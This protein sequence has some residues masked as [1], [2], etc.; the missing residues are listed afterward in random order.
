M[1]FTLWVGIRK[2]CLPL[3]LFQRNEK[4]W[5]LSCSKRRSLLTATTRTFSLSE[6]QYVSIPCTVFSTRTHSSKA[7]CKYFLTK[8]YFSVPIIHFSVNFT[9]ITLFSHQRFDDRPLF[10]PGALCLIYCHIF[11]YKP[12]PNNSK[13]TFTRAPSRINECSPSCSTILTCLFNR[14]VLITVLQYKLFLL[15]FLVFAPS[16]DKSS[17]SSCWHVRIM[18][19]Y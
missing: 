6:K 5:A 17:S 10:K 8:T 13:F 15:M 16:F 18:N 1:N 19:L 7:I 2:H 11:C 9:W 12:I 14:L 3:Y 4:W